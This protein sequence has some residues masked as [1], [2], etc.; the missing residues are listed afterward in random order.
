MNRFPILSAPVSAFFFFISVKCGG[1]K[2]EGKAI[3]Y[4]ILLSSRDTRVI[5]DITQTFAQIC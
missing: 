5:D 4:D 2:F 3:I 1:M